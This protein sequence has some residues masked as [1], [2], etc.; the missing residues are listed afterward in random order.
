MMSSAMA[1]QQ[2]PRRRRRRLL[3]PTAKP[4]SPTVTTIHTLGDDLGVM[5]SSARRSPAVPSSPPSAR[6]RPSAAASARST[7][8]LS[9]ES[10]SKP[11]AATSPPSR[12]SA[13]APTRTS[14]RP[15]AAPT[16]SSPTCPTT[17]T[18][19]RGWTIVDCHRG[20]LLL[21]NSETEQIAA[22]NP[23][24]RALHL[25]PTPPDDISKGRRGARPPL[26][27][28]RD[29]GW[30]AVHGFHI[31]VHAVHFVLESRY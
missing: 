15:S 20:C 21:L 1:F 18:P 2:P 4:Q 22:Y 7:R 29:K 17:K 28:W 26:R 27:N 6:P 31:G 3:P 11:M 19:T 25:L 5:M 9:S 8:P 23:L 16:S 13:A 30:E 24:T 10:S 12:P 14:P